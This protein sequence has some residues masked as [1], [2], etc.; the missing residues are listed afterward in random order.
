MMNEGSK[1]L[2]G[3]C[4]YFLTPKNTV[5][6]DEASRGQFIAGSSLK[7]SALILH[8]NTLITH[9]VGADPNVYVYI[10]NYIKIYFDQNF[11]KAFQRKPQPL[12]GPVGFSIF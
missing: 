8:I 2:D 6:L 11:L 5:Y 4:C 7:K 9:S 10:I 3:S 12:N 1:V